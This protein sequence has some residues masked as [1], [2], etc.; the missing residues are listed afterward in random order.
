MPESPSLDL[1][2]PVRAG[3]PDAAAALVEHSEPAL[4]RPVRIHLPDNRLRRLPES[5]D[6]GPSVLASFFARAAQ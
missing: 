1:I 4:R 2:R 6:I 5:A 3:Y